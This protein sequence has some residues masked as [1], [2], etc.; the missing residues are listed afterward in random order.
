MQEGFLVGLFEVVKGK[1][2][3]DMDVVKWKEGVA[4]QRIREARLQV[5]DFLLLLIAGVSLRTLA[6]VS[7][8]NFWVVRY[9][10]TII[11]FLA[12]AASNGVDSYWKPERRQG[13]SCNPSQEDVCLSWDLEAFLLANAKSLT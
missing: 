1:E 5:V 10:C 6:K 11:A 7:D 2:N 4:K 3:L 12:G 8:K 13:F 9:T